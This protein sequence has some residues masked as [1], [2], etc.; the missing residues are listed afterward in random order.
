MAKTIHLTPEIDD[1]VERMVATGRYDSPSDVVSDALTLLEDR[2]TAV[3]ARRA[4]IERRI[5]EG[6]S[7]L[8]S[9]RASPAEDVFRRLREKVERHARGRDAAE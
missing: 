6:L 2:E 5:E 4:K 9:G 7:D 1:F 3:A 8:D